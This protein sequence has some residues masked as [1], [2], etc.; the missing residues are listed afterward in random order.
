M[1]RSGGRGPLAAVA[2][3]LGPPGDLARDD[4]EAYAAYLVGSTGGSTGCARTAGEGRGTCGGGIPRTGASS[5]RSQGCSGRRER[6]ASA[7]RRSAARCSSRSS[8]RPPRPAVK[9]RAGLTALALLAVATRRLF[10]RRQRGRRRRHLA[11]RGRPARCHRASLP[12]GG[13]TVP[14]AGGT[15]A[16]PGGGPSGSVTT[17]TAATGGPP[18]TQPP[19]VVLDGDGAP[20]SFAPAVLR[21]TPAGAGGVLVDLLAQSGAAPGGA[22]VDHLTA[23]LGQVTGKAVSA[24]GP[25]AVGGGAQAWTESDIGAVADDDGTAQGSDGRAVLHLVFLHGTFHG[26]DSILGVAV[27][28]DVAAIFSDQVEASSTPLIGADGIEQAVVTHEVGHLLGLVD[29]FLSTGRGRPRA[30]RPLPQPRVGDV[31]G[32]RVVAGGRPAHRRPTSRLRRRRPR[33]PRHDPRRRAACPTMWS[34]R[35]ADRRSQHPHGRRQG[36]AGCR[37]P[38]DGGACRQRAAAAGAAEVFTVGGDVDGLA[39]LG[40]A[41]PR[42]AVARGGAA[43]RCAGCARQ[44]AREAVVMVLA[45]DLVSPDPTAIASVVDALRARR[46][47]SQPRARQRRPRA[48]APRRVPARRLQTAAGCVRRRRAGRAPPALATVRLQLRRRRSPRPPPS[49]MPTSPTTS[50]RYPAGRSRAM[51][52]SWLG[53][54]GS[55][56]RGAGEGPRGRGAV[57]NVREPDEYARFHVPGAVLVPLREVPDRLDEL[58]GREGE[59]VFVICGSGG[60]EPPRRGVPAQRTASMPSTSPAA[61]A[62]WIE[63][64]HPVVTASRAGADRR[65]RRVTTWG[66]HRRCVCGG[67]ATVA[68]PPVRR[69]AWLFPLELEAR[70]LEELRLRAVEL[71]DRGGARART[72]RAADRGAGGAVRGVPHIRALP[73]AA[74]ARALPLRPSG[75]SSPRIPEDTRVPG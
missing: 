47:R 2:E 17:T 57:L 39:A 26:D 15:T 4:V 54:A 33:R 8:I 21:P 23:V 34:R 30:P 56:H 71:P 27:R 1:T 3:R 74:H 67:V 62:A 37:R 7:T 41:T 45:Y 32:G 44:R 46:P 40:L 24:A 36:V 55:G 49:P 43:G 60:R 13:T 5:A 51:R 9:A 14:P 52:R 42:R 48:G 31:L 25:A 73:G 75:G 63:A 29:L 18:S 22:S 16:P 6:S 20:G 66:G 19:A 12:A 38:A 35:G 50:D 70:R 68:R 58:P 53:R 59:R 69:R 28:G 72:P 10:G 11:G 65:R 64:G 61:A